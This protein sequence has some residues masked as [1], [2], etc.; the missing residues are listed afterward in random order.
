MQETEKSDTVM[1]DKNNGT[2]KE[3]K[4]RIIINGRKVREERRLKSEKVEAKFTTCGVAH[5][6]SIEEM[7]HAKNSPK[8]L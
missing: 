8:C 5:N 3:K 7:K 6:P 1:N 2:R 4:R